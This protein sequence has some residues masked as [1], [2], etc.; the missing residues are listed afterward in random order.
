MATFSNRTDSMEKQE[1]TAADFVDLALSRI[2]STF[3]K[4][5]FVAG[6]KATSPY[7]YK[8]PEAAVSNGNEQVDAACRWKHRE[9]FLAFLG[10]SLATQTE[11]VAEYL[12][13]S[14]KGQKMEQVLDEWIQ[15]RLY[16]KL[17]PEAASEQERDVF[18][19]DL[20]AILQLLRLRLAV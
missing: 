5:A 9:M 20:R 1:P 4:L 3:G 2:P 19:S 10:S 11:E 8:D 14:G 13:S 7:R 15:G 16:D 12:S 17:I 18:S 6:I